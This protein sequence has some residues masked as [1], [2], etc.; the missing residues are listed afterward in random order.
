M[1]ISAAAEDPDPEDDD[2]ESE[3]YNKEVID[4]WLAEPSDDDD[5]LFTARVSGR[6]RWPQAS[7]DKL[8]PHRGAGV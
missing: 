2:N 5:R 4:K 7:S 8:T 1:A 3:T 6:L